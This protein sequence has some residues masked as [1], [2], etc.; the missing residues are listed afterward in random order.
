MNRRSP[1]NSILHNLDARGRGTVWS[2]LLVRRQLRC[3]PPGHSL[4]IEFDDADLPRELAKV[5][6]SR[7]FFMSARQTGQNGNILQI[8]RL[9]SPDQQETNRLGQVK[10]LEA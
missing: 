4:E 10:D 9:A 6:D 1:A 8:R 2:I 3:M 5:L 7:L